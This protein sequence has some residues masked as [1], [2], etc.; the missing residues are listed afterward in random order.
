MHRWLFLLLFAALHSVAQ[1]AAPD[2]DITVAVRKDG[3]TIF[4]DV[5][6]PVQAPVPLI[7]QVLTDYDHMSTFI[8]GLEYSA[9][10]GRRDNLLTVRQKGKAKLGLFTFN[11]ENVREVEIVPSV[12]IRSHH[13]SGDLESSSFTTRVINVDG[14]PHVINI[15]R[16]VPKAWVPP[17]VGPSLIGG[18]TRKQFADI[19][20]EIL[21]RSARQTVGLH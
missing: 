14:T 18:E 19:R 8:G 20:S 16:Y 12:E 4:V 2:A 6:C 11:F 7:W 21:R 5:D 10:E 3:A 13:I 9:I 17:L 1:P 15:G